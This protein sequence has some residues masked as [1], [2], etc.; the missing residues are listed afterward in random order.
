MR[1]SMAHMVKTYIGDVHNAESPG[2]AQPGGAW[3]DP[4]LPNDDP[5]AHAFFGRDDL[6]RVLA[7]TAKDP[8]SYHT[9]YDA[10]K[11]YTALAMNSHAQGVDDHGLPHPIGQNAIGADTLVQSRQD[12]I[13]VD[14]G[15]AGQVF[16]A[17]EYGHG[18]NIDTTNT[19]ADANYNGRVD[20][21]GKA[22]S[23]VVDKALGKVPIPG[24][25]TAADSYINAL[26]EGSK[27][28]STGQT[29][30]DVGQSY[31]HSRDLVQGLA[32]NAMYDNNLFTTP[33]RPPTSLWDG[34]GHLVHYTDMTPAQR[35]AYNKWI[36]GTGQGSLSTVMT[37]DGAFTNGVQNAQQTLAPKH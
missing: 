8:D 15:R 26:I 32:N 2:G 27:H 22:G 7:D 28:D 21:W 37:A 36:T 9:M 29:N 25:G 17:L 3:D 31:G 5:N 10:E 6:N 1:D 34:H 30:F 16:G 18:V 4:A 33:Q 13:K 20:A 23:F 35:A 19:G 14:A 12:A 11:V 24:V